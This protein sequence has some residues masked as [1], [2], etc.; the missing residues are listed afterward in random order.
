MND[1]MRGKK[2]TI[3]Y[4][5]QIKNGDVIESTKN[6]DPVKMTLG[7][8]VLFR[9]VEDEIATMKSGERKTIELPSTEAFGKYNKKLLFALPADKF[10]TGVRIGNEYV[11]LINDTEN[12]PVFVIGIDEDTVTVD[13]NHPL[14]GKDLVIEVELLEVA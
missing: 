11:L 12:L 14:A 7:N 8:G 9:R 2:I 1:S 3:H 6:R 10:P 5:L 4:T 13:G